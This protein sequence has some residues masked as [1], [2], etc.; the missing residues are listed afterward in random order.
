MVKGIC[1]FKCNYFLEVFFGSLLYDIKYFYQI[2]K[3]WSQLFGFKYSYQIIWF[4]VI[5]FIQYVIFVCPQLYS[6]KYSYQIQFISTQL[7]HIK[8]FNLI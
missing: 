1:L 3:I 6:F 5:I 7:Y 2:Q 8:D 4:Q